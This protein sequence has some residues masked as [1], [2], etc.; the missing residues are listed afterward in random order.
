VQGLPLSAAKAQGTAITLSWA[1][2]CHVADGDYEIYEGTIGDFG[3]YRW[4]YCSTGGATTMTFEPGPDSVFY[5]VVPS[6]LDREGSYGTDSD[7]IER[8]QGA[9]ACLTQAVTTTCP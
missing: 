4:K 9:P 2:S 7:G 8:A 1:P 3:A 5:L 6:N